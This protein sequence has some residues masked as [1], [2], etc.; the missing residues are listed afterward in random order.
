LDTGPHKTPSFKANQNVT[1]SSN[2]FI[3][4]IRCGR[5]FNI[6]PFQNKLKVRTYQ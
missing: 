1:I 5:E 2:T 6:K 3:E 4:P